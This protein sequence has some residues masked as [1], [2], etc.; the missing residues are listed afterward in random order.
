MVF[1]RF[2]DYLVVG[3][4][5][6]GTAGPS[7]ACCQKG[8]YDSLWHKLQK[9]CL[10]LEVLLGVL[11]RKV[12]RPQFDTLSILPML[13]LRYCYSVV[14]LSGFAPSPSLSIAV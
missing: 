8:L 1:W 2:L 9:S 5:L 10:T 14:C 12:F 7:N 11:D 3:V 13:N 4:Y 6:T